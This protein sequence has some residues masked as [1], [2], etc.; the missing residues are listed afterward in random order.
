METD[1]DA[2]AAGNVALGAVIGLCIEL[3]E[4]NFLNRQ[5]VMNIGEFML[6]SVDV[7]QASEGMQSELRTAISD[8]MAAL[9]SRFAP[10][11]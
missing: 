7:S 10:G 11:R 5:A 1:K 9:L 2:I 8:H 3:A 4:A 6:A